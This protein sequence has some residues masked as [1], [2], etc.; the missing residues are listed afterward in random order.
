ML[1]ATRLV[2]GSDGLGRQTRSLW[3][4]LKCNI[5]D[6]R[7][8]ARTHEG[9]LGP[10]SSIRAGRREKL[11]LDRNPGGFK[12]GCPCIH[13]PPSPRVERT[14][15]PSGPQIG[16]KP[17][18]ENYRRRSNRNAQLETLNERESRGIS[19]S[20]AITRCRRLCGRQVSAGATTAIEQTTQ[21]LPRAAGGRYVHL[22][23]LWVRACLEEDR[24][25]LKITAGTRRFK[26]FRPMARSPAFAHRC[27]PGERTN[28]NPRTSPFRTAAPPPRFGPRFRDPPTGLLR[29]ERPELGCPYPPDPGRSR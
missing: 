16:R 9:R 23:L 10:C 7:R 27:F 1:L 8:A 19:L 20:R 12:Q 14:R 28:R 22:N 18:R 11:R 29:P 21:T 26:S 24:Y 5:A 17:F 13:E 2:S 4:G 6:S 3:R 25:S 15:R